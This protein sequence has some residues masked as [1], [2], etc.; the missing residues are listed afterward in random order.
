M[1]KN[2]W[3]F[4]FLQSIHGFAV[5]TISMKTGMNVTR[6]LEMVI[7]FE[8]WEISRRYFVHEMNIENQG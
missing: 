7:N 3:L 2:V 8:N 6:I 1:L 5:L 4:V